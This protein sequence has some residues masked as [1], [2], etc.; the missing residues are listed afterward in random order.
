MLWASFV[1]VQTLL[2]GQVDALMGF[3]MNEALEA[4]SGGMPVVEMPIADHGVAAYGLMIASS[5]KFIKSNPEL[6][7]GFLRATRRAVEASAADGA[8]SV[9]ALAA[10]TSETD[11]AREAKVLAKTK[12]FWFVK[13]ND[14]AGFGT[15]TQQGWQQ[16]VET[17]RSIWRSINLVNL[18]E[19]VLPTRERATLVLEKGRD[20]AVRRVRL[21]KL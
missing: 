15:Q 4:E 3:T 21:R 10:A 13:G 9:Q 17:A 2:V 18:R 11:A 12:P 16:T 20:H 14:I 6:V 19:N 7:R 5:D 1:A 8:A